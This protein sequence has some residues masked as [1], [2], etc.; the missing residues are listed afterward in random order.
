M[1]FEP[2]DLRT[3]DSVVDAVYRILSGRADE[4]R[5]WA[6]LETLCV[7]AARLIGVSV[8]DGLVVAETLDI[9]AY[10][11]SRAPLLAS[12]DFYEHD[13]RRRVDQSGNIAHVWS[14]YEARRSPDGPAFMHGVGSFQLLRRND[15]WRIMSAMWQAAPEQLDS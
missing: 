1:T 7:P 9:V 5:D 14:L 15:R 8:V 10:A 4:P 2:A 11:R 13:V 6:G 12:N 3:P